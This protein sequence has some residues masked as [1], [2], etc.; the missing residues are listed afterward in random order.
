MNNPKI[1]L[2]NY[3]DQL[4]ISQRKISKDLGISQGYISSIENGN[5]SPTLRM[6]YKI[7][8]YLEICPC[9]LLSCT[10]GCKDCVRFKCEC[11]VKNNDCSNI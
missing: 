3:R 8:D 5:K 9:L 1:N 11:E 6:L 10:I 4:E 2:K 7:A